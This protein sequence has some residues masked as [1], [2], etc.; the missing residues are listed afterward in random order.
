MTGARRRKQRGFTLLEAIVAMTL[1]VL[2]LAVLSGSIRFASQSREVTAAKIDSNDNMRIAQDFLRQTLAQTSQ[3]RW[4]KAPG[5][6]FVFRGDRDE[7]SLAA[8]LT[9]RVGVGGL[10]LLKISLADSDDRASKAKKLILSRVFP[11]PD[12]QEMPDF[13]DT[14]T[15]VLA[16]NISELEFQYLGRDDANSDPIWRDDWRDGARMPEAMRVRVKPVAGAA[17][18]DL[19][20]PLRLTQRR[21]GRFAQ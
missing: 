15:T 3:K 21:G 2:M 11:A 19:I 20:V 6:P 16:E 1:L 10:F 5:R 13:A 14:E 9:A 18:P 8:P 4:A 7:V 17:W 12:A